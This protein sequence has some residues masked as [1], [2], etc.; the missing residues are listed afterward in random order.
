MKDCAF[1]GR[2]YGGSKCNKI[3]ESGH[4]GKWFYIT[5]SELCN[6]QGEKGRWCVEA[7]VERKKF[8]YGGKKRG[9]VPEYGSTHTFIWV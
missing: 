3:F 2:E 6:R 7:S 9:S 5:C 8:I 4:V 1:D